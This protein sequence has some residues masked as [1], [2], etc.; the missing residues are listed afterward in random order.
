METNTTLIVLG[1]GACCIARDTRLKVENNRLR[2]FFMDSEKDTAESLA[3]QTLFC[4]IGLIPISISSCSL[5]L[6]GIQEAAM[7]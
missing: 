4:L 5:R 3:C 2:I 7:H 1:T 6:A